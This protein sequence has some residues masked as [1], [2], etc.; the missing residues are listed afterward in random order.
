MAQTPAERKRAQRARDRARLGDK[1]YKRVEAEKMK[2]WRAS[3]RPPKP[4]KTTIINNQPPPQQ[5]QVQQQPQQ[6]TSKK[7][8]APQQLQRPQQQAVKDFV[9]LYKS[10][11]AQPLN[12]KSIETYLNQFKKV[13]EHFTNKNVPA[14]LK[15]ELIKV[16]ELKKYDHAY[17]TKE[18]N[19]IKDTIKFINEL[20]LRYPNKNSYKSHLNS[21]V[22]NK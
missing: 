10:P 13:Y 11:N 7:Q 20:K 1:E 16:L 19:F 17:V 18:L 8:K 6:K 5:P 15:N 12:I 9:P 2:K 3:K 4:K 14:K 22:S 21:I